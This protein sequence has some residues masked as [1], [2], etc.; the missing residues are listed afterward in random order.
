[1]TTQVVA[2]TYTVDD[3]AP[4]AT[5]DLTVT[6]KARAGTPGA[7][8]STALVT[9]SSTNSRDKDAVKATVTRR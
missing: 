5:H 3:L 4:G 2:G 6:I 1:M 8:S 7:T 9:V